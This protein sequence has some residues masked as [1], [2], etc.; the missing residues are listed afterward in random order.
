M[1]ESEMLEIKN[2]CRNV[3]DE[4]LNYDCKNLNYFKNFFINNLNNTWHIKQSLHKDMTNLQIKN[5]I[6]IITLSCKNKVGIKL[7]GAGAGGF[8]MVTGIKNSNVLKKKLLKKKILFFDTSID[9]KGSV[10]T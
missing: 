5:I 6:K 7:L 1:L 4:L 9:M 10:F 8:I 3:Y 2:I